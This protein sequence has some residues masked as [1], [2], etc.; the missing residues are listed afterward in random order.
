[1]S[2]DEYF[3][4]RT[5][6][7]LKIDNVK[8]FELEGDQKSNLTRGSLIVCYSPEF[9]R[10]VFCLNSFRYALSITLPTMAF[11]SPKNGYRS[12]ILPKI[13]GHYIVKLKTITP[14]A[15]LQ[16]LETILSNYSQFSYNSGQET[17]LENQA[18][19]QEYPESFNSPYDVKP[20][21]KNDYFSKSKNAIH[22]GGEFLKQ[23]IIKAADF[24]GKNIYDP[25]YLNSNELNVKTIEELK[26]GD[27]PENETID[28]PRNEVKIF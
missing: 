6:K 4:V 21:P 16:N 8:L 26:A 11:L 9:D 19:R 28:F 15:V 27:F 17:E 18:K 24:I 13:N 3:S 10:F 20:P 23:K 1:M 7:C 5:L 2:Q 12:Y 22:L 25:K 14:P